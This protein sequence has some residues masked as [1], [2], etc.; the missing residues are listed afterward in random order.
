MVIPRLLY[1]GCWP[2]DQ[3]HFLYNEHGRNER[4]IR[5]PW[6]RIDCRMQPGVAW[7]ELRKEY[8]CNEPQTE[9]IGRLHYKDGWTALCFWDRTEDTRLNSNSNFFAEGTYTEEEMHEL[10]GL[11]YP[12]IWLRMDVAGKI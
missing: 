2:G 9:G 1:F 11:V 10:A 12:K 5:L 8:R 7:D 3:G 6:A 4:I